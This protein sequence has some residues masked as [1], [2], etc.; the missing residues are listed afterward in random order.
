MAE[1]FLAAWAPALEE[2]IEHVV[3]APVAGSSFAP[4]LG[5]LANN[6][7]NIVLSGAA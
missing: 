3:L 2:L 6:I 4:L 7:I 5:D 1:Q